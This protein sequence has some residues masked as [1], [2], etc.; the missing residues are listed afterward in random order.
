MKKETSSKTQQRQKEEHRLKGNI[1][2]LFSPAWWSLLFMTLIQGT[3]QNRMHPPLKLQTWYLILGKSDD[4][5]Q[6]GRHRYF[7]SVED[8]TKY[9][10]VR[11]LINNSEKV[12]HGPGTVL[13]T[14]LPNEHTHWDIL[15]TGCLLSSLSSQSSLSSPTRSAICSPGTQNPGGSGAISSLAFPMYQLEWIQ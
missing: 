11:H 8:Q 5:G 10:A 14:Q 12:V 9:Q 7:P 2:F 13:G 6:R 15:E 4:Q 3:R 1:F